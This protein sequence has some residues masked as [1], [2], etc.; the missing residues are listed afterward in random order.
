VLSLQAGRTDFSDPASVA[1]LQSTA[2]DV[3]TLLRDH[4][5]LEDE[6]IFARLERAVP[7]A[8]APAAAQHPE[9]DATVDELESMLGGYDGTQSND[10]GHRFVLAL[11]DFQARYLAH[12]VLE[13]TLI[14]PLLLEHVTDA[15]FAADQQAVVQEADPATLLLWFRYIVPARRSA[16][17]RPIIAGFVANAP[18]PAVDAVRSMLNDVLDEETFRAV[19]AE[20]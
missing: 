2:A 19:F 20:D 3:W 15:E 16:D 11:V 17:S 6:F 18:A 7:G 10:E 1:A 14:E 13:E 5:R 9:L 12:L 8:S 4:A